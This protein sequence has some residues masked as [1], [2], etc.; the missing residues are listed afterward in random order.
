MLEVNYLLLHYSAKYFFKIACTVKTKWYIQYTCNIK[1]LHQTIHESL[2]CT[3]ELCCNR[4]L[5][6]QVIPS[7]CWFAW[8]D[9]YT[10][11]L[12]RSL[13]HTSKPCSNSIQSSQSASHFSKYCSFFSPLNNCFAQE[14]IVVWTAG[15]YLYNFLSLAYMQEPWNIRHSFTI[16]LLQLRLRECICTLS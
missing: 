16:H 1:S 10:T 9:V 3:L 14:R 8:L 7:K 2:A 6:L 5:A 4:V 15:W 13:S 12:T 11:A